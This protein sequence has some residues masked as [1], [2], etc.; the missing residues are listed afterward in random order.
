MTS[1]CFN[2]Q[3]VLTSVN[4]MHISKNY[5]HFPIKSTT[6]KQF[7]EDHQ[8]KKYNKKITFLRKYFPILVNQMER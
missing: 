7:K 3:Y 6:T 2:G 4:K 5:I 8:P 1:M